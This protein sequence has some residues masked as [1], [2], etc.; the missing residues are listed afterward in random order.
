MVRHSP[1]EYFLKYLVSHPIR[2]KDEDIVTMCKE[3][4]LDYLGPSYLD[5]LKKQ[6]IPPCPFQPY[7]VEHFPSQHFLNRHRIRSLYFKD[8]GTRYALRI[9]ETPKLKEFVEAMLLVGAPAEVIARGARRVSPTSP[10]TGE[11]VERFRHF[12]WNIDLLDF[13]EMRA[14]L[15]KRGD[16]GDP[17][18]KKAFKKDSRRIAAEL[19]FSP[20]SALLSQLR[21]G[22]TPVGVNFAELMEKVRLVAGIRTYQYVMEDSAFAGE[23][24]KNFIGVALAATDLLERAAKPEELLLEKFNSLQLETDTATIPHIGEISGGRHTTDLQAIEVKEEVV[25]VEDEG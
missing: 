3:K 21:M 11:G 12:F 5:L 25:E 10:V 1:A 14:L 20:L 19:P 7:D 18:Y 24:A 17:S 15:D 16:S 13:T 8:E 4:G 9:L 23:N 22:I 6:T 2:Y